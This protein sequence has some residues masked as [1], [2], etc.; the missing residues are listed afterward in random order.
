MKITLQILTLLLLAGCTQP[1]PGPAPIPPPAPVPDAAPPSDLFAGKL[2]DC[3]RLDTSST[4]P[5][6]N[7][8]GDTT[9]VSSCLASYFALG[10]SAAS[11]ACAARDAEMAAFVEVDRGTADDGIKARAAT[12]RAWFKAENITLRSSP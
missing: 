6:A 10:I 9:D 4:L 1:Q 3:S 12:L 5:A 7:T 11:L 2:F 8:C